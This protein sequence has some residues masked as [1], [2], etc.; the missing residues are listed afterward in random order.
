MGAD[1]G[2]S[3]TTRAAPERVIL[4]SQG[5]QLRVSSVCR[6]LRQPATCVRPVCIRRRSNGY[7]DRCE[8]RRVLFGLSI[9]EVWPRSRPCCWAVAEGA[10]MRPSAGPGGT[11]GVR[12]GM[13]VPSAAQLEDPTTPSD[14]KPAS[15]WKAWTAVSV[16]SS[17]VP[18][19]V[20]PG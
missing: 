2:A 1:L 6:C 16:A 18:V 12:A 4:R 20:T 9:I 19:S 11:Q 15:V 8:A 14:V 3:M 7:A 17:N 5:E 13:T 10:R